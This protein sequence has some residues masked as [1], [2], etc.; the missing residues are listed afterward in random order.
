MKKL[1]LTTVFSVLCSLV[2]NAVT[3][4]VT[5]PAGTRA[6]Y[7]AGDFN[8]WDAGNAVA[9]SPSGTN[10]FTLTLDDVS[11]AAAAV[12]Y[13]YLCGQDWAYVEKG[14]SG[15]EI[16]N[17]TAVTAMDVVASW[18]KM[19]NPDIIETKLVVNGYT[20]IV[21]VFLPTDYATSSESYPVVYM[22]GVQAR[23]DNAGSDSDRGDDHLGDQSWNIPGI[24]YGVDGGI[25]C[26]FVS[27]Y[28]FVAENTPYAYA[29]FAGSGN[30]DSFISAIETELMPYINKTYRTK[31]GAANT[32]IVGGDMGGLF[33]VYAALKR[34][35]LFG[36]CAALSPTI[37]MNRDDIIAFA[38]N[39][40]ASQGQRFYL[41]VGSNE[42]D[43]IKSD[44]AAL[45]AALAA[46]PD[47][48]VRFTTFTG[49]THNDVA[50]GKAFK[51]IYPYLLSADA[52]M[53]G[54]EVALGANAVATATELESTAYSI[55]S[56]IDSQDLKYDSQTKFAYIS[57]FVSGG[58][59]VEAQVAIVEIPASVKTKYYW[60]VSRSADG[61]GE[62]LKSSNG[63]I[64]FSSK[65]S[66]TTWHRV[67][68]FADESVKDIAAGSTAFR[69]VTAT[70]EVTMTPGDNYTTS[71]TVTFGSDK[72]FEIYFGSVN[73]GSKQSALTEVLSVPADCTSAE[74][75][76]DFV[77]NKVTVTAAEGGGEGGGDNEKPDIAKTAYSIV[78]AVDSENLVYDANSKFSYIT[79]YISSGKETAVQVTVTE[80]PASVKTQYYWN[81]SRSADGKGELLKSSNGNVSFS[82]KK[83]ATS[84]HR[85]TIFDDESVKDVAANSTAFRLATS[86]ESI[87]MSVAQKY[88][89][90]ASATFTGVDKS[91]TIHYGSVNS[92]SDMGAITD[93][94]NVSDNCTGADISYDFL[95]NRVTITE[96]A[97]GESVGDIVVEKFMAVPSFCQVGTSSTVTLALAD[98]KGY[99]VTVD[100]SHNYGSK[101]ARTLTATAD[102][103]WQLEMSNLQAGIYH[104]TL[105]VQ[106]GETKVSDVETIAIKVLND[107]RENISLV[108]PYEGI[109]WKNINQYKANF[110]T[111][112]TQSFD[113]QLRVDETVDKYRA[114]GYKILALTEHDANP[115]PWELFNM[116]NPAA[117]SRNPAELDMLAIPGNELSKS[118]NNSWNEVGGSEFN[119]HNDFFT[120]RQGQEFG[121]LRESYAYTQKLGGMQLINHPGQYWNLANNYT[122]G[123]KNSPEWHAENF[124]TYSSLIGLEVYNQGNRRPND[125]ILWDQ[126]LE[127]TMAK[128]CSVWGYSC[129]DSHNNDQLFRNYN[130]ML[131]P[132]LTVEDLK[133]AMR[134]GTHYFCYEYSGSGEAKA[135]RIHNIAVDTEAHTI[136]IETDATNV[137][138]ISAT[139]ISNSNSP[140][141]RK[142]T[143][144]AVGK[145]FDYTG[146]NG[147]YVRALLLNE[148]GETCTQPFGFDTAINNV[149]ENR[150]DA[151]NSISV[152]PNPATEV[153][154]IEA[155]SG[156]EQVTIYNVV[157]QC[158]KAVCG[159]NSNKVSIDVSSLAQGHYIVSIATATTTYN[160]RLVVK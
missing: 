33:S 76:Y 125:R 19:S 105:N 12:G 84:W 26:I 115:Y 57:N 100:V 44:V 120:G 78:S 95:T 94:Y 24:A 79:N 1:L 138:W 81:V 131:M 6:C 130:F 111:H 159:N 72:S 28:G 68:V 62:L 150:A 156:I 4:N 107:V 82:S 8:G 139:D 145:R 61:T 110:H 2:M 70:Q 59:E 15:E 141:T 35:D 37:W 116:Y 56:A 55:V 31:Q 92:G 157:G 129:D 5:V 11:E 89:V 67:A 134:N 135:P 80:I 86:T 64:G 117:E 58:N 119:H 123:E 27:M 43:M 63:N 97:W 151:T 104:I 29:D 53:V 22:T 32:S 49:A 75:V 85:V 96:T 133:D 93:I 128:G 153:V 38:G 108:N 132:Q 122:P 112:T 142:S 20:R 9:M 17:R 34:P 113:A 146:F 121:T 36:Q 114:A 91:F 160:E 148:Y 140:S 98:A 42:P 40:T 83:N 30:A 16:G 65:K 13:K 87:T 52:P 66:A 7:I 21:K 143:V 73:S 60:N 45:Q 77:T 54:S 23:Y 101:T 126:I 48:D 109:D 149:V 39:A 47:T 155:G 144:L 71:A 25:P 18:A 50:W 136:T 10:T 152:Y 46:R 118:Y 106:R 14:A 147:N 102:G 103:E 127:I 3:F 74:I 124:M 69:V 90:K 99:D 51:S 88:S 41:S 158:A 137:Y 154:N